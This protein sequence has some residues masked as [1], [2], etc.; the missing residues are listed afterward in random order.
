MVSQSSEPALNHDE[1]LCTLEPVFQRDWLGSPSHRT[2]CLF[3]LA[4]GQNT[5]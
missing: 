3:Q 1:A 2:H 4:F 5:Q